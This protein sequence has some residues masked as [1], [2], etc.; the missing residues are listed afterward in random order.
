[1]TPI[2]LFYRSATNWTLL[3]AWGIFLLD[4]GLAL[5][6]YQSRYKRVVIGIALPT[7]SYAA[8]LISLGV[9]VGKFTF[10]DRDAEAKERFLQLSILK[11]DTPLFYHQVK[12]RTKV[13]FDGLEDIN[14]E[15]KIWLNTKTN[16]ER[17]CI[18]P[19]QALRVG[20]PGKDFSASLKRPSRQITS[21]L[22]PFISNLLDTNAA[23]AIASQSSLDSLIIGSLY[24]LKEE[25]QDRPFAVKKDD[26]F[27]SGSLQDIVRVRRFSRGTETYRSEIYQT[28][29]K[30]CEN[31]G[32]EIPT[33]VIFDG[34]K[35]FLKWRTFWGQ[36]H[37]VVLLDQTEPDFDVAIQTF[38][39]EY[40]MSPVHD[41]ELFGFP[42]APKH[43]P[44]ATY[45]EER[46]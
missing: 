24:R 35:S 6:N 17:Y 34:A 5:N 27:I 8:P 7:L 41:R 14:G 11:H 23:A 32:Q 37:W 12:K 4:V 1:M 25:I 2:N 9:T 29:S 36:S 15:T 38:N 44:I 16:G 3:P 21:H 13:F 42:H 43:I 18:T 19:K 33:V 39:N 46:L 45:Q 40:I 30:E 22:S 10:I 31:P 28:N 20:F 26:E